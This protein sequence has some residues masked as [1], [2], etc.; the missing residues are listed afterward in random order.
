MPFHHFSSSKKAT[1][2]HYVDESGQLLRLPLRPVGQTTEEALELA[3]VTF[4]KLSE[5]GLNKH[6]ATAPDPGATGR[7]VKGT[8]RSTTPK[9]TKAPQQPLVYQSEHFLVSGQLTFHLHTIISLQS[10][11]LVY[12]CISRLCVMFPRVSEAHFTTCVSHSWF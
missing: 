4:I 6:R 8:P 1:K 10:I 11:Q 5:A 7:Q 2:F 9:S 3:G 12:I